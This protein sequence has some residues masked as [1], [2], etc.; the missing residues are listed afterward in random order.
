MMWPLGIETKIA[1]IPNAIR[2]SSAQNSVRPGG[3]VSARRVAVRATGGDERSG[4]SGRLPQGGWVGLG[5]VGGDRGDRE[6]EQEAQAEQESDCDLFAA[7]GGG[8]AESEDASERRD[9]E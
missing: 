7:L 3:E 8:D 5:V 4:G 6:S 2:P 9:E 1:T